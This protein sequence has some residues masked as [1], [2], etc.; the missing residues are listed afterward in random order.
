MIEKT[1][2]ELSKA[3]SGREISSVELTQ[4]FLDRIRKQNTMLNAYAVSA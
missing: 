1:A 3:L 4:A 2:A